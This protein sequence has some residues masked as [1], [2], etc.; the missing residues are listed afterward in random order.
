MAVVNGP[1]RQHVSDYFGSTTQI[2]F[3]LKRRNCWIYEIGINTRN[4]VRN[5]EFSVAKRR[6]HIARRLQPRGRD[7][8]QSNVSP[9]KGAGGLTVGGIAHRSCVSRPPASRWDFMSGYGLSFQRLKPLTV[10][11]CRFATYDSL[12]ISRCFNSFFKKVRI[13][14]VESIFHDRFVSRNCCKCA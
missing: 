1:L 4:A 14:S 5:E 2:Q 11:L 9:E 13:S 6:R 8:A 3:L 7:P 12:S 10:I